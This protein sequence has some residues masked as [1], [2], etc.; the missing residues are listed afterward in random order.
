M[1]TC[2]VRSLY[3]QL[4][5]VLC[6][7][8]PWIVFGANALGSTASFDMFLRPFGYNFKRTLNGTTHFDYYRIL[9]GSVLCE[10]F[11]RNS[12]LRLVQGPP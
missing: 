2:F 8:S 1:S 9:S 12:E 4:A 5:V 6:T 10:R 7:D 11:K 3:A